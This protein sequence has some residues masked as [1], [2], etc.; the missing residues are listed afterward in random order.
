MKKVMIAICAVALAAVANAASVNW[1]ATGLTDINGTAA[2]DST[3]FN[4][5]TV[6]CTF[7]DSTGNTVLAESSGS[8]SATLGSFKGSW[9][10]AAVSTPYYAQMVITDKNGN[11][12]TSGKAAFTTSG[13]STYSINFGTGSKFAEETS[14]FAGSTWQAA[15]E[16]TSGLLLLLGMAGLAL[17]R[18]RA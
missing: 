16:P 9:T 3:L 13:S 6:V 7:W 12:I 15:P 18:K 11:T 1:S 2:K 4:P 5:C 14:K 17:K 8:F 10:G